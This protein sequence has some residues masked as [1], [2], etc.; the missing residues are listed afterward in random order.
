VNALTSELVN[1]LIQEQMTEHQ[2]EI[3]EQLTHGTDDSMTAEKIYSKMIANSVYVS[4]QLSVKILLELLFQSKMIDE[5][6]TK[7]LLELLSS[8]L[9]E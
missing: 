9:K 7:T 1:K 6:D 8:Y 2:T 4:T 3:L 5:P